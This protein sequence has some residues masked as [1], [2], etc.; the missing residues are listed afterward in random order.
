MS[1]NREYNMASIEQERKIKEPQQRLMEW[2]K[3]HISPEMLQTPERIPE[4]L[5]SIA[6]NQKEQL[7][8]LVA[9]LGPEA[10]RGLRLSLTGGKNESGD[11]WLYVWPDKSLG[12]G[13]TI[14]EYAESIGILYIVRGAAHEEIYSLHP[15]KKKDEEATPAIKVPSFPTE[16]STITVPPHY[17]HSLA[18]S[19]ANSTLTTLNGFFPALRKVEIYQEEQNG[20]NLSLKKVGTVEV[21]DIVDSIDFNS[22]SSHSHD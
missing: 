14:H 3:E 2:V 5:R 8:E 16:G 18:G 7:E 13:A 21:D 22:F 10:Q 6:T 15:S 19:E 11:I 4:A 17:I 1:E 12:V 20:E 9:A